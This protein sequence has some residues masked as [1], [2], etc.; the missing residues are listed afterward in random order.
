[1]SNVRTITDLQ[2]QDQHSVQSLVL[3][4]SQE[5]VSVQSTVLAPR[6]VLS[7]DLRDLARERLQN[8]DYRLP[9]RTHANGLPV[10]DVEE[11]RNLNVNLGEETIRSI[12]ES[13]AENRFDSEVFGNIFSNFS[14]EFSGTYKKILN[15][16]Y[17]NLQDL[18]RY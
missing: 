15:Q 2:Q 16:S 14:P 10:G 12:L 8:N 18:Y 4:G 11:M 6:L 13:I 7:D 17:S 3:R 1:M 9:I 5:E